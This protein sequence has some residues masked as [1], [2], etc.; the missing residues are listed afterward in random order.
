MGFFR[1]I[2]FVFIQVVFT[3]NSCPVFQNN[4]ELTN[5]SNEKL[6]SGIQYPVSNLT[7]ELNITQGN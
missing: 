5:M 4:D 7:S 1:F 6:K 3:A 2:Q